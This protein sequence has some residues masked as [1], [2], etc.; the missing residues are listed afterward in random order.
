METFRRIWVS[1]NS[2]W[3]EVIPNL[4]SMLF[5]VLL[6][7]GGLSLL[8]LLFQ[9]RGEKRDFARELSDL[10]YNHLVYC[11]RAL[12][13]LELENLE[14]YE[15]ARTKLHQT[16]NAIDKAYLP[17]SKLLGGGER[18]AY[19]NCIERL[20]LLHS[21]VRH[22]AQGDNA[23]IQ[24]FR[25]RVRDEF[26]DLS[27][28]FAEYRRL[29]V[30]VLSRLWGI[31]LN[32]FARNSLFADQKLIGSLDSAVESLVSDTSAQSSHLGDFPIK[33]VRAELS[34]N[35]LMLDQK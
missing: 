2:G 3:S 11:L 26:S 29:Q 31:T 10:T 24:T 4:P 9:R 12:N 22:E 13:A 33:D 15:Q 34:V 17:Y 7:G 1:F 5:E 18:S 23:T 20:K 8:L 32:P 19:S 25:K 35:E 21:R 14:K 6:L 28:P 16:R 30:T 27:S